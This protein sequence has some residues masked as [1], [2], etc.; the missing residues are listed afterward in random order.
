MQLY[1]TRSQRSLAC[2][3]NLLIFIFGENTDPK[4]LL[5]RAGI[6]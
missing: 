2:K 6:Q 4:R 5:K 3:E 1:D